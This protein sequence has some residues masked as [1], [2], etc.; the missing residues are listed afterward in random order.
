MELVN[1]V[2]YSVLFLS[3][4]PLAWVMAVIFSKNSNKLRKP[5]IAAVT[6]QTGICS[7][8]IALVVWSEIAFSVSDIITVLLVPCV[9]SG[10]LVS[11]IVILFTKRRQ[12]LQL[13]SS[14]R[15]DQLT[16]KSI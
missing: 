10:L 6:T 16:Y 2:L 12:L 14:H 15:E 7:V 8:L 9:L 3:L 5:V 13:L 11:A 1:E 4:N